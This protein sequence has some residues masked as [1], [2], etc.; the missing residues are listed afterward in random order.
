MAD[1]LVE[2]SGM[3]TTRKQST[4]TISRFSSIW[5]VSGL[6][7]IRPE[8]N[9]DSHV[10]ERFGDYALVEGLAK[11]KL[12]KSSAVFQDRKSWAF[13]DAQS[14][15]LATQGENMVIASAKG[16]RA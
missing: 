15:G 2:G 9:F 14:S 5:I 10:N 12:V 6:P 8:S 13:S 16:V 11:V 1:S 4:W 7:V 3:A